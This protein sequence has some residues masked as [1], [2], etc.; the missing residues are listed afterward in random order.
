MGR[1]APQG[2][3]RR[4][5]AGQLLEQSAFL[6][7][8]QAAV[9]KAAYDE[10]R[11]RGIEPDALPVFGPGVPVILDLCTFFVGEGQCRGDGTDD[12]IG[13]PD[14]DKLLRSTLDALGGK[15]RGSARLFADD[16]QVVG[17][18]QLSKQR[19]VP[20]KPTGAYIVVS[21]GRD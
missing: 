19:A 8:W 12:P 15:R 2:S 9:K 21:D 7:A 10:Y 5:G 6:P 13:A 14:L 1:P 16:A 4:G 20:G 17:I 3:K 11:R 18:R